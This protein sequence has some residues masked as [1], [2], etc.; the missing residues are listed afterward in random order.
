MP[1]NRRRALFALLAAA[2]LATLATR[3]VN[4]TQANDGLAF[5]QSLTGIVP[6]TGDQTIILP[7]IDWN[8][9]DKNSFCPQ[10]QPPAWKSPAEVQI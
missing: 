8:I 4:A 9:N 5:V 6:R 3:G 7:K 1:G 2:E 10:L